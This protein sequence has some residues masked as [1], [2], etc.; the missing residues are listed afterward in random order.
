MLD[1][2]TLD[3]PLQR[4][5]GLAIILAAVPWTRRSAVPSSMPGSPASDRCI[6]YI[7][8]RT[9]KHECGRDDDRQEEVSEGRSKAFVR[10]QSLLQMGLQTTYRTMDS[11]SKSSISLDHHSNDWWS[12]F[13]SYR[14]SIEGAFVEKRERQIV[15]E[16]QQAVGG[17]ILA[18][19]MIASDPLLAAVS[20]RLHAICLSKAW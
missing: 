2:A 20:A 1:H 3:R 4:R 18:V 12:R 7:E 8:Y 6:D 9:Q 15:S 11:R 13:R 10:F 19:S 5:V 16:S 14:P 17:P